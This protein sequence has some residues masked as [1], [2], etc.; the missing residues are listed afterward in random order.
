VLSPV[1]SLVPRDSYRRRVFVA[2]LGLQICSDAGTIARVD[3]VLDE[4]RENVIGLRVIFSAVGVQP[5]SRFRLRLTTRSGSLAF[6]PVGSYVQ[7][8]GAYDVPPSSGETEV[9][10]AWDPTPKAAAVEY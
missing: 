2:P 1:L 10:V 3:A 6:R 7:S 4:A 8:R 9:Q 5:L